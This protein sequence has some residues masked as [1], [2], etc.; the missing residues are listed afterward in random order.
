MLK[1]GGSLITDKSKQETLRRADLERLAKEI[2]E[3]RSSG[4]FKLVVGH[5]GGGFP[6]RP[7]REYGTAKGFTSEKS[8]KGIALA[9]DAAARLNRIVVK[10][11]VDAG[12]NAVSFQPSAMMVTEKTEIS[13]GFYDSMQI[14]LEKGILPVHYG[15][16]GFDRAQGCCIISTEKILGF[17]AGKFPAKRIII[18]GIEDGVWAD[19]PQ[20]T[21]LIGEITHANFQKVKKSLKGSASV[22]VTGG[23]LT[24]VGQML[25]Q[26]KRNG[27][28]TIIVNGAVP[29]RVRDALLG[30]KVR[31]TVIR[32]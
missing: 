31:G 2:H 3:A 25:A 11:L 13:G 4:K 9:A 5:G 19:F 24:K 22:D 28:E 29:G 26:A 8:A 17:L 14:A 7:A 1:L 32:A 27:T 23:M 15:D 30:R 6:H 10:A 21:E 20:N 18:A 16:V 12:E